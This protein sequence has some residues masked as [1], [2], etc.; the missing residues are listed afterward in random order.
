MTPI[1]VVHLYLNEVPMVFI[2]V[3]K[4]VVESA[5]ITMIT[6]SE[7]TNSLGLALLEKEVQQA[8]IEE[9][10]FQSINATAADRVQQ[11]VV[12]VIHLQL[13]ETV[14]I[15]LFGAVE[16]PKLLVLVAHLRCH[17]VFV[18]R[19]AAKGT[20][21]DLLITATTVHGSCI[22]IIDPVGN[23]IIHQTINVFLLTRQTHHTESQQRD[24]FTCT[25]LHTVG[26]SVFRARSWVV[27]TRRSSK[28]TERTHCHEG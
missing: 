10:T 21:Y 18:A 27:G 25:V 8:I 14:L 15:H 12:D 24:G 26:H 1:E 2:I 3:V 23:S 5:D 28:G 11:V 20:P 19:I 13:A 7:V 16:L 17:I 9:T 22:E 4:Q 6:E